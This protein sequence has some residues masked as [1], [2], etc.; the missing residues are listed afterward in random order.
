M[1]SSKLSITCVF[2]AMLV[3]SCD[4]LSVEMGISV[5]AKPPPTCGPDC[6]DEFLKEDCNNYCLGLSYETGACILFRGM[7]SQNRCCCF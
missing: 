1:G 4:L 7:P 6:T 3:I 2:V 5:E